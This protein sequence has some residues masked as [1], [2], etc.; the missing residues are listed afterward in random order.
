MPRRLLALV[1]LVALAACSDA[2][3]P[4]LGTAQAFS[5]YGYLDPTASHQAIRVAPILETLNADTS[6]TLAARVTSTERGTGRTTTWRDSVVTFRD[7]SVGH[8]FVADYTPTPGQ[9]VEVR[10]EET[11]G[12]RRVTTVEVD[13]PFL[14]QSEIGEPLSGVV[15]TTYPVTVRGVPRVI[16]GTLRLYVTGAPSAPSDTTRLEVP[17][18]PG[19]LTVRE[20]AGAWVATV[21]FLAATR[22][23]LQA[24]GL[25]QRGLT[26]LEAEFAPFVTSASWDLPSGG[27]DEEAVV[28]PGT[29]SNVTGGFGF[30]GSGFEAPVRWLPSPGTQYRAGFAI[31][32]D[33]AGF[34]AVNEVGEGFAELYNPTLEP[35]TLSGYAVTA[36]VPE[37][38]VRLPFGTQ[39]EG[40]AFLVVNGPFTIVPETEVKLLSPS[41]RLVSRM[42]IEPL[43]GG[44]DYEQ[45]TWGSYPDGLSYPVRGSGP[46]DPGTD[47]FH[48]P[49]RA[50]PGR[51]NRPSLVPAVINELYTEGETGWVEVLQTRPNLERASLFSAPRD[52]FDGSPA[53]PVSGT[54]FWVA[55][56][57]SGLV[58]GQAE[59]VVYLLASYGPLPDPGQRRPRRVVDYRAYGPQTP[60][61]SVGYLPDGLADPREPDLNWTEGLLPTRGAPNA[62][63]RLGL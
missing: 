61:R 3:D 16:G 50:T 31:E 46:N 4:T 19:Q 17:F 41:G 5:L 37:D 7:G 1:A 38:G 32:N 8:I 6:R 12:D 47:L 11:D 44:L 2:V 49:L 59:G 24:N 14:A 60:G 40:G 33:P 25:Y 23:Y 18:E 29:F 57:G 43:T 30:V 22:D 13:V 15:D 53:S 45:E 9:T 27:L 28:E 34:I 48:G 56:E 35:V 58:L 54:E 51:P 21:P 42:Y 26:L 63:A 52:L 36:G 39:I 20:E 62:A 10:V 55:E